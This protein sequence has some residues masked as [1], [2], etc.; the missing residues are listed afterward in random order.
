MRKFLFF[1]KYL[2]FVISF[3][4]FTG[5]LYLFFDFKDVIQKH[6][7]EIHNIEVNRANKTAKAIF[8]QIQLYTQESVSSIRNN[9]VIEPNLSNI[10]SH[11][12]NDEF[13]YIYLI[14]LD[15]KGAYRYL[16]DGS[17][18]EEKAGL[19]QKFMPSM[20]SLWTRVLTK[21]EDVYD[22]QTG[23]EGLW[24][25]YLSPL[26]K[27]G[28]I[29]AILVLDISTKEYQEFSKLLAPLSK[30]LNLFLFVLIIIF[31]VVLLQGLLFYGQYKNSLF[32]SLTKLYNRYYLESISKTINVKELT[33]LMLDIDFFKKIND[34]YGHTVGD[35]VI[36][37]VAQKLTVATRLED[38]VIRYGGEEFL[39]LIQS[40]TNEE[41]ILDIA[42]R[43]RSSIEKDSIRIN[44]TLSVNVTIS[45][46]I[47][48]SSKSLKTVNECIKKA[49]KMM[50][51]AKNSG[52][53]R[54]EAYKT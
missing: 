54:V 48:F 27:D 53:N 16:A 46:G 36:A 13:K 38:K 10:L 2:F 15:E 44:D 23:A 20:S 32:D 28:K 18:S 30:F 29:E 3:I 25:T 14:Y 11:Y 41:Y 22:I 21:K 37:S 39:I 31:L 12:R 50:Y 6:E 7:D 43:I 19:N 35:I 8:H 9:P 4:I 24:L 51:K 5:S 1:N 33:V 40:S 49:D 26:L 52:R 34:N 47:N 45:I 42:E 17:E